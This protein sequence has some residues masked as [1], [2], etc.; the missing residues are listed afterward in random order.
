MGASEC[1]DGFRAVI[2]RNVE[3]KH[4]HGTMLEQTRGQPC[5]FHK[6][7]G[8]CCEMEVC[9]L[10]VFGTPCNPFSDMRVKRYR[11]GSVVQHPLADVTFRDAHKLLDS[12][13]RS[14]LETPE[15]RCDSQV[16]SF[17]KRINRLDFQQETLPLECF[18]GRLCERF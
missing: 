1:N 6:D 7:L 17:G 2:Q 8:G 12:T 11:D 10:A 5:I 4:L 15:P 18:L 13:S 3:V 9:D 14:K 16:L